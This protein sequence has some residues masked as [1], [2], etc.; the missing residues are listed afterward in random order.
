MTG[1]LLCYPDPGKTFVNNKMTFGK[2]VNTVDQAMK[3]APA[4]AMRVVT[5]NR[6]RK[7]RKT[8]TSD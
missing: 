1:R 4:I 8:I 7:G 3:G 6:G 5:Y 2:M